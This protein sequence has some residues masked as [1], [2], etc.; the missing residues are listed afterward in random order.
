MEYRTIN[1]NRNELYEA[2]WT[3]PTVQLAKEY[4]ISDVALGKICKKL[5]VPKPGLGYWRCKERGYAVKRVPLPMVKD[6]PR[7]V[8]YVPVNP[9]VP[10]EAI[11]EEFTSPLKASPPTNA[12]HPTVKQTAHAFA[13]KAADNYGR[14]MPKDWRLPRFD[15][16][17]TRAGLQRA[18][19][20]MDQL[21]KL[22]EAND[23]AVRV[24][25]SQERCLMGI[26]VDGEVI[27]VELKE[28]VRGRKRDL[29]LEERRLHEQYP[30]I[31]TKDFRW[32]YDPTNRFAFEIEDYS[33][34][35]RRWADTKNKKI[36]DHIEQIVYGLRAAAAT[37]KR[38]RA[39]REAER[40]QY[41]REQRLRLKERERIE[42][43]KN[44]LA[45]WEEAQRIR[46]YLAAVR[47]KAE[48]QDG[49]LKAERSISRFLAWA[50]HYADSLDPAGAPAGP[51]WPEEL[52]PSAAD[53]DP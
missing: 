7:A 49:G 42:R 32:V 5:R 40:K 8:S 16:R 51:D 6:I 41:E 1:W 52:V 21:V 53:T 30:T 9:P 35:R 46:A 19:S 13:N 15:L 18:L 36:E 33:D 23:M 29:N 3:K 11:P 34:A 45:K 39:Q 38:M 27:R 24:G 4:G 43:L 22:L 10:R 48:S 50:L 17:V 14:L 44:N 12:I 26:E 31:Y 37:Q 20:F 25:V 47:Q 2:V 28:H